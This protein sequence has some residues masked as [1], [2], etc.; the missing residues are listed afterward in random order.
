VSARVLIGG[1]TALL[2]AMAM[3]RAASADGIGGAGGTGGDDAVTVWVASGGPGGGIRDPGV[4]C[5]PWRHA[6]ELTPGVGPED[7]PTV[8]I[9]PSGLI[10]GLYFRVC[11]GNAEYVWVPMVTVDVLGTLAFDEVKQKLPKPIPQLSPD[12]AIGGWVNFET[13]LAVNDPGP[14]TATASIVGLS[15]TA[16]A[17][18]T[19]IEWAPGDGSATLTCQPFGAL[20]PTSKAAGP[21]PCGHTFKRSSAKSGG[22]TNDNRFAGQITLV[23]TASWVGS[24][25]QAGDLGEFRTS[26]AM[27][28]RVREIQTIGV[29][30]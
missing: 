14:V 30:G 8:R 26:V 16:T 27:N 11:A 1:M 28:Y 13:W 29:E 23:W 5:T 15:A 25:G 12:P 20:P 6:S 22:G 24:N 19:R 18:V 10:W 21:A 4:S 2:L 7:A 17:R 3:P 9:D